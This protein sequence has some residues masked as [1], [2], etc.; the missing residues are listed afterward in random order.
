MEIPGSVS[1]Y[2]PLIDAKGTAATLVCP[3]QR[4]ESQF[5]E[6]LIFA[7]PFSHRDFVAL[8]IKNV[9]HDLKS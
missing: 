2:C 1:V 5:P 4:C 9:I 3:N 7:S 8:Q 6:G